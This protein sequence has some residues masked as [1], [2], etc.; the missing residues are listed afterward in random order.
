[1]V[2]SAAGAM[3]DR[4]R[5]KAPR[6]TRPR[7]RASAL[8]LRERSRGVVGSGTDELIGAGERGVEL[9][10]V[11][12]ARLRHLGLAAAAAAEGLRQLLDQ[13]ACLV[14]LRQ[15]G[16][17]GDEE[18]RLSVLLAAEDDDPALHLIAQLVRPLA[19]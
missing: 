16:R 7:P 8:P 19:Q 17:D 13:I 9:G 18:R 15:V 2:A 5:R 14:L 6:E 10:R 3:R 1:R 12:A 11:A 4:Q